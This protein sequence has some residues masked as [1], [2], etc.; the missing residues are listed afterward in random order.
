MPPPLPR[1]PSREVTSVQHDVVDHVAL[2][3][4]VIEAEGTAEVFGA[5]LG[6]GR[7]PGFH[8]HSKGRSGGE[9]GDRQAISVTRDRFT[10]THTPC[11]RPGH[12]LPGTTPW[13]E[14]PDHCR[15]SGLPRRSSWVAH[16]TTDHG[17]AVVT[18][19]WEFCPLA[20][21]KVSKKEMGFP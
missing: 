6:H 15:R 14:G 5:L 10:R 11:R 20:G 8:V 4:G 12:G 1:K 21:F 3:F 13:L 19:F 7:V 18:P 17:R 16:P 2:V 9:A